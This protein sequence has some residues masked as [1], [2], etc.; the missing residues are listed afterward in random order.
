MDVPVLAAIIGGAASLGGALVGGSV[1]TVGN[2]FLVRRR[3]RL[4]FKT[5]SRLVSEE[6]RR[7]QS[8]LATVRIIKYRVFSPERTLPTEAWVQFRGILAQYLLYD[9]WRVVED[10]IVSLGACRT[11]ILEQ[12]PDATNDELPES[13]VPLI[14]R[15]IDDIGEAYGALLPYAQGKKCRLSKLAGSIQ[16]IAASWTFKR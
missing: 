4:E 5:A 15:A 7:A 3:E 8:T 16:K 12:P 1:V 10:A 6:L 14:Q 13:S 9:D 11:I 2:Y